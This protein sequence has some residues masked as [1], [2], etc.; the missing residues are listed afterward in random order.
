MKTI[1]FPGCWRGC[2]SLGC[3]TFVL[4]F[5]GLYI[6]IGKKSLD[7]KLF[8]LENTFNQNNKKIDDANKEVLFKV[9]LLSDSEGMND[10][11]LSVL[12]YAKDANIANVFHMGDLTHLG[13][14]S[15][16]KSISD[17]FDSSGLDVYTV[18]G[19]RDLWK[20]KGLSAYN[21]YFGQ[22]Y[23]YENISGIGFLFIDNSNEYEGLLPDEW[24]FIEDNLDKTTFVI[25]HNALMKTD[26]PFIGNKIMGE[27]DSSVNEQRIK[28]LDMIRNSNVK[29]IFA[30]DQHYYSETTD[31]KKSEL[32]QYVIGTVNAEKSIQLPS[33]AILSVFGD[34]SYKV[35]KVLLEN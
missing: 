4:L 25:V 16:L 35:D 21:D 23:H 28:L 24:K 34:L 12:N 22:S 14:S 13:V 27:Y 2:I 29:A 11:V 8:G 17:A 19:D 31:S 30:G 20:S 9:V 5:L 3:L 1:K 26:V 6:L 32:K 18:P 33:F 15:N 10:E 7:F